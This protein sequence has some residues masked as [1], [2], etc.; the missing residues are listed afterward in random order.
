M[1]SFPAA[2]TERA[3]L[4]ARLKRADVTAAL[5]AGVLGG[6]VALLMRPFLEGYTWPLLARRLGRAA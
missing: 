2:P 5:G 6:G 1:R 3:D 4:A